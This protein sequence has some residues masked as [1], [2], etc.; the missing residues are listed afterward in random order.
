MKKK[1]LKKEVKKLRRE[2][3][4][5]IILDVLYDELD[6]AKAVVTYLENDI[7]VLQERVYG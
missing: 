1:K 4:D 5:R 7:S 3:N 6:E 2:L